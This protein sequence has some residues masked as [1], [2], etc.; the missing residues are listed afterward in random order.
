MAK[1]KKKTENPLK[2]K[3]TKLQ[4]AGNDLFKKRETLILDLNRTKTAL[5]LNL[6]QQHKVEEE[7]KNG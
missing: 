6:N 1:K 2:K 3:L 5:Q 7:I 4:L